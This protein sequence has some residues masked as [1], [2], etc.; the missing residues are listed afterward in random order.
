[1]VDVFVRRED[2]GGVA[3][4]VGDVLV[5]ELEEN[6]SAGYSWEIRSLPAWFQLLDSE[7]IQAP[8]DQMGAPG[9]RRTRLSVV[10]AGSGAI[11]LAFRRPWESEDSAVDHLSVPVTAI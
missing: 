9:T 4:R 8:G 5:I 2:A 6:L 10:G 3:A 11:E 1:M 7:H